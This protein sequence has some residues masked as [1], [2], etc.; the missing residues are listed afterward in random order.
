MK[1]INVHVGDGYS[2]ATVEAVTLVTASTLPRPSNDDYSRPGESIFEQDAEAVR[3]ALQ[4]LPQG[5]KYAL[6]CLL[7]SDAPVLYRGSGS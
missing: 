6:L 4:S 1:T 7:L 5:T 3:E 2:G